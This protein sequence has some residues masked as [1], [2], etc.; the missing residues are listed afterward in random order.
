MVLP[1]AGTPRVL[2][3][4]SVCSC[5]TPCSHH[6]ARGGDAQISR[7]SSSLV[8][9]KPTPPAAAH[10][11]WKREKG[12]ASPETLEARG[13]PVLSSCGSLG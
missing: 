12:W 11:D 1:E 8:L 10:G 9:G 4:V 5:F 6:R 3:G 13:R 7:V 2:C